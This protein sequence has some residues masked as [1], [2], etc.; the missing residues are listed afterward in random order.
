[1]SNSVHCIVGQVGFEDPDDIFLVVVCSVVE[2][3]LSQL[4]SNSPVK[5][6]VKISLSLKLLLYLSRYLLL[7]NL[8]HNYA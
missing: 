3:G 8:M 4:K 7:L 5:C 2:G 1:M 6:R